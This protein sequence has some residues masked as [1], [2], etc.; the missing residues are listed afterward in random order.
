M[1]ASSLTHNVHDK[2]DGVSITKG[3]FVGY[4][5]VGSCSATSRSLDMENT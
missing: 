3:D 5:V 2:G 4:R 1:L